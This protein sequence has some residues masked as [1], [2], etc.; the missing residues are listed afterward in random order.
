[1]GA[2]DWFSGIVLLDWGWVARSYTGFKRMWW[3]GM[4]SLVGAMKYVPSSRRNYIYSCCLYWVVMISDSI[5]CK[6]EICRSTLPEQKV[7]LQA[8]T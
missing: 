5:Y 7:S 1:M 6:L 2:A 8:V 4:R 3:L